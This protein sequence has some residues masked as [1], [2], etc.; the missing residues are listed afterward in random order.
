MRDRDGDMQPEE[1]APILRDVQIFCTP[2]IARNSL[3]V[4]RHHLQVARIAVYK[5]HTSRRSKEEETSPENHEH[6]A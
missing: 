6:A 1:T 2:R 3:I 4:E 5:N